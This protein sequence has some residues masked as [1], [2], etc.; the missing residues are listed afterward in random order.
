MEKEKAQADIIGNG[1]KKPG[2]KP[3]RTDNRKKKLDKII[4]REKY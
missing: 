2:A 1:Y 3:N 4:K